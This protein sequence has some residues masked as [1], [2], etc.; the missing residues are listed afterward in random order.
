MD[1]ESKATDPSKTGLHFPFDSGR[2]RLV[3]REGGKSCGVIPYVLGPTL[4]HRAETLSVASEQGSRRVFEV[5]Q[6]SRYGGHESVG[7][8]LRASF[9]VPP[10]MYALCF[11]DEFAQRDGSAA[12]LGTEPV[13]MTRQQS[14]FAGNDAQLRAAR[15]ARRLSL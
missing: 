4:E 3:K 12:R 5:R 15:A 14:H 6:I 2:A 9:S 8:F 10:V 1:T 11:L 13:P 7:D